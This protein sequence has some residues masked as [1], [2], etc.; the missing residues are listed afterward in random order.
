MVVDGKTVPGNAAAAPSAAARRAK[1]PWYEG[2]LDS[3]STADGDPVPAPG[4]GP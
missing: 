4:A 2:L 1:P 3:V